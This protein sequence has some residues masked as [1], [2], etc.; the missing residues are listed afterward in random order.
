VRFRPKLVLTAL[1]AFVVA[2][3]G[4][5]WSIGTAFVEPHQ[6]VVGNAP[7]DL[8]AESVLIPSASGATIH[9]WFSEVP[10]STAAIA[11]FHGIH[12][13]RR[14][15]L[16][17]AELFRQAGYSVLLIDFQGHGESTASEITFGYRESKDVEASIDWLHKRMPSAQV[18]AIGVSM[19][20]AA[21]ALAKHPLKLNAVVLESAY[22]TIDL[23]VEN[24][25]K[26]NI[27]FIGGAV[28]PLLTMQLHPRVGINTSDLRPIDH[29]ADVGCPILVAGG[30]ADPY[31]VASETEAMYA[32]AQQPK[33]MWLVPGA[34]HQ[35]LQRFVPKDYQ[36]HVF[37]FLERYLR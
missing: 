15:M 30:A 26:S 25:V 11:L 6:S 12:A 4:V 32:T 36:K 16:T 18:G 24:R 33:E 17:R 22:S 23:A 20:G 19:G 35:D 28:W 13:D 7:A 34:R 5:S 14:A 31:T 21:L 8:H 3:G 1:T 27:G 37:R 29:L 9:G 2:T 10:G